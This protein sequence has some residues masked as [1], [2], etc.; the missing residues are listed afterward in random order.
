MFLLPSD[1][2]NASSIVILLMYT[3][4]KRGV[5]DVEENM[6]TENVAMR[7]RLN[8]VTVLETTAY[9][10]SGSRQWRVNTLS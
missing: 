9:V 4:E 6:H 8:V 7:I 3:E 5:E 10:Q 2:I 1:V